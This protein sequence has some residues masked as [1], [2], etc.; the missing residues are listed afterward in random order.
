MVYIQPSRFSCAF[1]PAGILFTT[2]ISWIPNHG[3]SFL[4]ANS[5]IPGEAGAQQYIFLTP[6]SFGYFH[7]LHMLRNSANSMLTAA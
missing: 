7:L 1:V 6:T 3:A 2:F 5:Q 4:G